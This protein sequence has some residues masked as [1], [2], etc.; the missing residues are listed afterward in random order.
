MIMAMN[1]VSIVQGVKREIM[2]FKIGLNTLKEQLNG[3][4]DNEAILI[5]ELEAQISLLESVISKLEGV[6]YG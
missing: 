3:L 4:P 2:F 6:A 5:A 1:S